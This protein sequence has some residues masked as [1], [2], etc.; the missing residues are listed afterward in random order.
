[1]FDR[2]VEIAVPVAARLDLSAG[3]GNR[4]SKPARHR[5]GQIDA[6]G[7][8]LRIEPVLP[9]VAMM[10]AAVGEKRDGKRG[11]SDIP[12]QTPSDTDRVGAR[13]HPDAMLDQNAA[14][15]ET[16]DWNSAVEMEAFEQPVALRIDRTA[17]PA[18]GEQ[19]ITLRSEAQRRIRL[20]KNQHPAER[21]IDRRDQQPVIAP[22]QAQRDRTAG[23]T[24]ASVG[25][26]PFA[27]FVRGEIVE[28]GRSKADRYEAVERIAA[29]R[30]Q[31]TTSEAI[32]ASCSSRARVRRGSSSEATNAVH[33]VWCA[34]PQPRSG[35]AVEVL[36]EQ[37]IILEI[38]PAL[39]RCAD[40]APAAA[41]SRR[42]G[43]AGTAGGLSR[44]RP[45]PG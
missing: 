8:D 34:A 3:G 17:S 19:R 36:E 39:G 30:H 35:I 27:A 44:R 21:R 29:C 18:V 5:D 14:A 40:R 16:P 22:G 2:Q 12:V 9:G 26:P 41:R 38:R 32:G 4:Q 42:A 10:V 23:I 28:F 43:R 25:D 31:Q 11:I 7:V 15:A 20:G 6:L 37:R 45:P 24:A 33:P 1:M 13:L